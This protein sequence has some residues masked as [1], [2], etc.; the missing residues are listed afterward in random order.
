M[1]KSAETIDDTKK[2]IEKKSDTTILRY[3]IR[4]PIYQ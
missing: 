2:T 3:G 4:A 1:K